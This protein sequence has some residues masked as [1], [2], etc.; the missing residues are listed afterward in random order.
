VSDTYCILPFIHIETRT[1]GRVSP[2]CVSRDTLKKN[3]N[4]DFH[5][6]QDGLVEAFRSESIGQLRQKLLRGEKHSNCEV[7]WQEESCG[8]ESKRQRENIR[9][10]KYVGELA[11]EGKSLP[12]PVSLDL[13]LGNTCNLKCRIC[14][15]NNS[16]KWMEENLRFNRGDQLIRANDRLKSMSAEE[17]RKIINQWP[18]VTKDFWTDLEACLPTAEL[19]EF[20]GGEPMLNKRHFEILKKSVDAGYSKNQSIHYNTNGTVLPLDALKNIFPHFKSVNIMFSVD[21]TRERF[22]YQRFPGKFTSVIEN[23]EQYKNLGFEPQI[24]FTVSNLTIYNLFEDLEYWASKNASVYL[25]ML[26][27]PPE[28]DIRYIS[29]KAKE[30]VMLKK[31]KFPDFQ[32]YSRLQNNYHAVFAH[33]NSQNETDMTERLF[34]TLNE[35][36]Q[37]RGQSFNAVFPEWHQILNL[38]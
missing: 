38:A 11:A 24:C 33:M 9:F 2:C 34:K 14:G 7:C 5:L 3:E 29:K 4:E 21:G 1:D 30:L 35:I 20:F 25:N 22:E 28:L 32:K 18:E 12:K 37:Y 26:Y 6:S 8:Q 36:D 31:E 19:I 10:K 16:S 27:E 13:K 17:S 15:P 23:Y